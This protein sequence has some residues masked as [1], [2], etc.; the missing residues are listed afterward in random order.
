L[1]SKT[2]S[3]MTIGSVFS[4]RQLC[5]RPPTGVTALSMSAAVVPG[6][7]F[8]AMTTK[9]PARP[10]MVMPLFHG[11][12]LFRTVAA[13]GAA[14]ARGAE[15]AGASSVLIRAFATCAARRWLPR[16]RA[17]GPA[18]GFVIRLARELVA[19][20]RGVEGAECRSCRSCVHSPL[21]FP[22]GAGLGAGAPRGPTE[23]TRLRECVS[24]SVARKR[25]RLKRAQYLLYAYAASQR[26]SQCG[27]L[28][29]CTGSA[30]FAK[31]SGCEGFILLAVAG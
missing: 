20:G 4:N 9:G 27:R 8:C 22:V 15:E 2:I 23:A 17:A 24:F 6:A 21:I 16:T 1:L 3:A 10:L 26:A 7:K 11:L 13:A 29:W 31:D 25:R 5:T 28:G 19:A 12:L 30:L 14:G 18:S